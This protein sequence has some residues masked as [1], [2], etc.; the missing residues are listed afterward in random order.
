MIEP[1]LKW[2]KFS[3]CSIAAYSLYTALVEVKELQIND[4]PTLF[5]FVFCVPLVRY[6]STVQHPECNFSF[7]VFV[8][9]RLHVYVFFIKLYILY[10]RQV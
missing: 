1:K 2:I 7:D 4:V 10:T 5:V 6:E 9:L 3:E 8:G